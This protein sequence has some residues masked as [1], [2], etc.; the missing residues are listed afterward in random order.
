MTFVLF[1][2]D[3]QASGRYYLTKMLLKVVPVL[4]DQWHS[5]RPNKLVPAGSQSLSHL[6][7]SCLKS[8]CCTFHRPCRDIDIREESM[9]T[10]FR[11]WHGQG[12]LRWRRSWTDYCMNDFV[13]NTQ[14]S[15]MA[16]FGW[17]CF[18]HQAII[19]ITVI[20]NDGE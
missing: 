17:N 8:W 6:A 3:W 12:D 15:S 20:E 9:V 13:C 5:K 7:G 14:Y 19:H 1:W 16:K 18:K 4:R 2:T 11:S 10:D